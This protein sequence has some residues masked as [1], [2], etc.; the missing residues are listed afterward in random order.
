LDVITQTESIV[1]GAAEARAAT[2]RW[3]PTLG[4]L[5]QHTLTVWAI[6]VVLS[7]VTLIA[8]SPVVWNGFVEWDDQIN[9][10]ENLGYRGLG[11]AQF[12]YFFTTVL[13]GHW[14]PITWM[15]FGLD[16]A[17]WGMN[18]LGYHL[19]IL[20]VY[21]ASAAALYFMT[22]LLLR[23]ATTLD[24][25]ALRIGAIA[26]TLFFTLHPL[27]AESVAWVTERRDVLSGLFFF[28]TI[29]AYLKMS[30]ARGRRRAWLLAGALG[31]YV[32]ALASKA[33]VMVLPAV[34]VLL[35]VYPLRRFDRRTLLEKIP[36]AVLGVAGAAV[37]YYAQNANRFITPLERYPL[38]ARV[39]MTFYGLWFYVEKTVLP[40]KLSPLYELPAKVHPLAW[41]FLL[42]AVAVS[43]IGVTLVA[44]RRRWPAGLATGLYYAF[45]LGPVIGIVHSGHQ[46]THD[47]YSYLP[48][49]GLAVLVGGL[50]G[51]LARQVAAG[52][53]NPRIGQALTATGVLLAAGLATLSFQQVQI[54][55]DTDS[56]WRYAL[57][58]EPSCSI[59]HENMGLYLGGHG[60]L[61]Q[62]R[63]HFERSLA[64][65]PDQA[66]AHNLLGWTHAFKGEP[67]EAAAAFETYLKRRPNDAIALANLASVLMTLQRS[68][69]AL[70]LM[71]RAEKLRPNS[72][73][74]LMNLGYALGETGHKGEALR[75]FRRAISI[76]WDMP[77][78]WFGLARFSNETGR[79]SAALGALGMLQMLNPELARRIGPTLLETW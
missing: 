47:R 72:P 49:V 8:F 68:Q 75:Y 27:R 17:L 59:C 2:H 33:S 65:R 29:T 54:W 23:K 48:G 42:P 3:A 40:L 57:D 6:P 58:S 60:L 1:A 73:F 13:M 34:L 21:A 5:W 50:V 64:L 39:G 77:Q 67:K 53:F 11:L 62:A 30:D 28:L 19:T 7:L 24:G 41:R 74:V 46:L 16:Y 61:E 71:Q 66:N 15:T 4:R 25:A 43:I 20:I 76:K 63:E 78:P 69:E 56:L 22:L 35:D 55:R 9:I 45:T 70:T 51:I 79:H 10:T 18:P 37:T 32:L 14:I 44:L 38:S 31:L 26:G 36:F 52:A 12:K